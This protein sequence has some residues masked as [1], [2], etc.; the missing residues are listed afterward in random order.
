MKKSSS[1]KLFA[2]LGVL[3][4]ASWFWW[5]Q[6]PAEKQTRKEIYNFDLS[7]CPGKT[8]TVQMN[9]PYLRGLIEEKSEIEVVL[10]A[11][12]CQEIKRDDLVLYRYSEFA[13]PVLRRVVAAPGDTF[14]VE[15]KEGQGWILI[16]NKKP[17]VANAGG[18]YIFGG[19]LPPPL[20]LAEESHKGVLGT[21]EAILFSSFPPGDK[22]S[23]VFGVIS[24]SDIIGKVTSK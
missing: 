19:E 18:D 14:S 9:D 21:H 12:S 5:Q 10:N 16:V 3:I 2:L 11:F 15:E 1:F 17:V 6:K 22:D 20:A 13:E 8:I 23:G 24:V 4:F 7:Q